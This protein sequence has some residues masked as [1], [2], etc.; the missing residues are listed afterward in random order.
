M[1]SRQRAGKRSRRSLICH[2]ITKPE[3]REKTSWGITCNNE[4]VP[5]IIPEPLWTEN[6]GTRIPQDLRKKRGEKDKNLE[7]RV[8]TTEQIER[9]R[10]AV[11][12]RNWHQFFRNFCSLLRKIWT[13][14]NQSGTPKNGAEP[15]IISNSP[16]C[17]TMHL[18]KQNNPT[19]GLIPATPERGFKF[20]GR[21]IRLTNQ[22]QEGYCCKVQ[23]KYPDRPRDASTGDCKFM[24]ACPRMN[25]I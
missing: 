14:K 3:G 15:S 9:D 20:Y 8:D 1:K 18:I 2:R 19:H 16:R 24:S 22:T 25:L 13:Q 21:R 10:Q 4:A 7:T 23:D 12:C 6:Q 5:P 17:W 11:S